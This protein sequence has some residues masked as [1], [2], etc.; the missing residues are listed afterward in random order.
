MDALRSILSFFKT[1][2]DYLKNNT[3]EITS[4]KEGDKFIRKNKNL[5]IKLSK[6]EK[7]NYQNYF[8]SLKIQDKNIAV[9][10]NCSS[11]LSAQKAVMIGLPNHN[12]KGY[13]WSTWE[14]TQEEIQKYQTST[15]QASHKQE[16]SDWNMMEWYMTAPTPPVE[17]VDNNK[18]IFKPLVAEER[19]RIEIY[20][21]LSDGII[22]YAK[23]MHKIFGNLDVFITDTDC[24]NWTNILCHIPTQNDKN[25]FKKIKHAWDVNH[26]KYIQFPANWFNDNIPNGEC[27][28]E[29]C[30]YLFN[31]LLLIKRIARR[32]AYKY[33]LFSH[34]PLLKIKF[35]NKKSHYKLFSFIPI[36]K[37]K[38]KIS[39][40]GNFTERYFLFNLIPFIKLK[41][42]F[43][44]NK[45]TYA[46]YLFGLLV[47]KSTRKDV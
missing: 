15:F 40:N 12:I 28:K 8:N 38:T 10:D 31:K 27:L 25:H 20:P 26:T 37:K 42:K 1:K 34:I 16:F 33:L 30:F 5:F 3:P 21:E 9:I 19:K 17:Y 18:V 23:L 7:L 43:I 22:E 32:S 35:K 39:N 24:I 36:L 47:F 41:H 2:N 13:Y 14:G 4:V 45:K 46:F 29:K 11:K 6:K 44:A